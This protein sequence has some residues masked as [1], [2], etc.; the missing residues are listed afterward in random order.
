[1]AAA[2]CAF[3]RADPVD[4]LVDWSGEIIAAIDRA[5]NIINDMDR[6]SRR[7]R[8]RRIYEL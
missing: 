4:K 7:N 1:V 6:G 8:K 5:L 2:L 3:E